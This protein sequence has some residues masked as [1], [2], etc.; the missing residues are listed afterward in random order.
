MGLATDYCVKFTA[1]DAVSLGFKTYLIK[2]G[3]RGV[4][5]TEGDVDKALQEMEEKGVVM[6]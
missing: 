2:D 1:L 3:C 4:N 5:L 6:V